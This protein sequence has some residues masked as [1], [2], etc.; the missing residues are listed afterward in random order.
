M[1]TISYSYPY[2]LFPL[3]DAD[4]EPV[5]KADGGLCGVGGFCNA[6]PYGDDN[7]Q[8][9]KEERDMDELDDQCGMEENDEG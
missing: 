1:K 7:T 5:C 4:K 2:T 8:A 3:T 9:D 6:C